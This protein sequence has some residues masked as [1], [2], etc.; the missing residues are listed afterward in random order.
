V[1]AFSV[2]ALLAVFV[3]PTV[4]CAETK[5]FTATHTYVLGGHDSKDDVAT[6]DH[7]D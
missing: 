7:Y 4:V 6:K 1:R 3:L 5:T 2:I